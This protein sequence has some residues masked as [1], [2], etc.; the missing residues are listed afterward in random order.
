L[1]SDIDAAFLMASLSHFDEIQDK[2]MDIWKTY[3]HELIVS[4]VYDKPS[5][6][7]SLANAH[8]YYLKFQTGALQQSFVA[9]MKNANVIVATHY[10]PLDQSPFIT[11]MKDNDDKPPP[12][13]NSH[14]WYKT[15]VR[16]PLFYGLTKTQQSA[17]CDL[18]NTFA[19]KQ[20]FVLQKVQPEHYEAI[21]LIR[22]S[23]S[24]AFLSTEQINWETHKMF[25]DR[26]S[27]TYRVAIHVDQVVGFV[28]HVNGDFRIACD[29]TY[30]GRGLAHFMYSVFMSEFPS[31]TVRVKRSNFRSLAFF[32]K[33]GLLPEATALA[34]G[35][36]PVPLVRC[37]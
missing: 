33:V 10:V 37:F 9:C 28:G 18:I 2:R 30:Q 3:D 16:L 5:P 31:L 11:S 21:L 14:R 22:N 17:I 27:H 26:H 1:L 34:N 6:L 13:P 36:D 19:L 24:E 23:H 35:E 12:C 25:M 8:M 15:L 32:K 20:G 7:V 4:S 29:V